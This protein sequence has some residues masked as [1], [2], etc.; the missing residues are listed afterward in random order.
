MQL[1]VVI[2]RNFSLMVFTFALTLS[3]VLPTVRAQISPEWSE[4]VDIPPQLAGA[5]L[6][7]GVGYSLAIATTGRTYNLQLET[8]ANGNPPA[9]RLRYTDAP[10]S[11]S[12]VWLSIPLSPLAQSNGVSSP[13][14]VIDANDDLHFAWFSPVSRRIGHAIFRTATATWTDEQFLYTG[15]ADHPVKYMQVEV[16][17]SGSVHI[18]WHEG[19]PDISADSA[20]VRYAR[21]GA[22]SSTFTVRANPLNL[23]SALNAAFP[24]AH[25]GGCDG[26]VLAV[27]WREET[28]PGGWDVKMNVTIDNGVTWRATPL[29]IAAGAGNQWDP[30]IVIDRHNIVHLTYPHK[31]GTVSSLHY[32]RYNDVPALFSQISTTAIPLSSRQLT[33]DGESHELP[34]SCYDY[35]RD[36]VWLSWKERHIIEGIGLRDDVHILYSLRKGEVVG[37]AERVTD[38]RAT[39]EI[40]KF[41]DFQVAPD[42]HVFFVYETN[43]GTRMKLMERLSTPA[44]LALAPTLTAATAVQLD[45]TFPTEFAVDYQTQTSTDL[46]TWTPVGEPFV[47]DGGEVA[48]GQA[49]GE[50]SPSFLRLAAVRP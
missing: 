12:P 18:L 37:A 49:I 25:F 35:Q 46:H 13:C 31:I 48:I 33:P 50:H 36:I 43:T 16:D 29:V 27:A 15:S 22:G 38:V 23:T 41:P 6:G 4:P 45:W 47:G 19:D 24:I 42:G 20:D 11:A 9:Y 30:M 44:A 21:R 28:T 7:G 5:A 26:A 10:R 8:P 39:E 17:R 1:T 32:L 14:L 2:C 3:S 34:Y 40:A